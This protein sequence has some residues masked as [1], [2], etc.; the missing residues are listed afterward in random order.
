MNSVSI[1]RLRLLAIRPS[2]GLALALSWYV[3]VGLVNVSLGSSI[4]SLES[5]VL[6]LY[7]PLLATTITI[8]GLASAGAEYRTYE[9][10]PDTFEGR[11]LRTSKT[12]VLVSLICFL[13]LVFLS[14][15]IQFFISFASTGDG[16]FADRLL[17]TYLPIIIDAAVI[18][19]GVYYGFVANRKARDE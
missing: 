18:A 6:N 12:I 15:L 2:I 7:V 1:K 8:F 14:G 13:S 11:Y 5:E 17:L 9:V 3:V 4:G 10:N 19:Y 16:A